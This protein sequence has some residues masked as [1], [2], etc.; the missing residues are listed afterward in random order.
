M[1]H[2]VPGNALSFVAKAVLKT[3]EIL[4]VVLRATYLENQIALTKCM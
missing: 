4:P 2:K 1:P 3:R